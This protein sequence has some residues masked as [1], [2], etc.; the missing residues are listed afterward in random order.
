MKLQDHLQ[1]TIPAPCHEQWDTMTLKQQGRHCAVCDKVVVDF[2]SMSDEEVLNYLTKHTGRVCGRLDQQ[3]LH[4]TPSFKLS[5]KVSVFLYSLAVVFLISMHEISFAQ[6]QTV[7]DTSEQLNRN[8]IYGKVVDEKGIGLDFASVTVSQNGVVKGGAK[9]QINGDY[10]IERLAEG[11]Y[12]MMVTYVGYNPNK[13]TQIEVTNNTAQEINLTLKKNESKKV[14]G[15][16]IT[17]G[18]IRFLDPSNPNRKI[19]TKEQI[20]HSPW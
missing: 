1:I 16:I 9:T 20:K 3:Q 13:R 4:T 11:K 10:K 7:T 5:R 17:V 6:G 15:Q 19:T 12:D 14:Q 2:A 8:E 18:S